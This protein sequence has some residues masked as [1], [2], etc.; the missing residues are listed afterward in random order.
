ME[1][2]QHKDACFPFAL[3]TSNTFGNMHKFLNTH[4]YFS[5]EVNTY[6]ECK[7]TVFFQKNKRKSNF[8]CQHLY[9]FVN[10]E[11]LLFAR[12]HILQRE[13]AFAH[14][15]LAGKGD[16]RNVLGIGV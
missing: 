1:T 15:I 11:H 13:L 9:H 3:I 14:L 7:S 5:I 10:S 12:I 2:P 6:I 8:L 4:H 16:E